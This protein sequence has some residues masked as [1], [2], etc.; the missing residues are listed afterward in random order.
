MDKHDKLFDFSPDNPWRHLNL[1]VFYLLCFA[2]GL[3][4]L[5]ASMFAAWV[6]R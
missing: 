1:F 4:M 6:F 3:L 2:L 5:M